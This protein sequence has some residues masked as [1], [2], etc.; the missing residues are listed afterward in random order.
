[1]LKKEVI[2]TFRT[3]KIVILIL[4][5]VLFGIMNPAIAKLT[6]WLME[7]M[8]EAMAESGL[9]ITDIQVDAMTSWTQ[10]FKNIPIALIFFVL[11]FSDIFTKEYRS[12]TLLLVLTKGLSRYKVVLAKTI[13][14]LLLWTFGYG[15]CFAITYGYNAY[16]W[17]NGIVYNVFFSAVVWWLFGIWVMCLVVIFS[18]LLRNNTG[19]SLCTGGTVL[20]AYLLSFVP[21]AN[22][23]SPAMLMNTNSLLIGAEGTDTYI[24]AIII[25]A[26]SGVICISIS[27]PIINKKQL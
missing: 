26:V 17:D 11:I 9:I 3:G 16:F 13:L 10:F 12:G 27:I 2:E 20:L 8:S 22:I 21:K 6:P 15:I 7:M 1:F 23:Y 19:V 4:L 5:F 25:A 14:L 18:S 24:K